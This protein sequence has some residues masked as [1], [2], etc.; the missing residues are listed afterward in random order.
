[1]AAED[2]IP[3]FYFDGDDGCDKCQDRTGHYKN[4]P[5]RPHDN[6]DCPIMVDFLE[7]EEEYRNKMQGEIDYEVAGEEVFDYFNDTDK[8]Q[9]IA[10]VVSVT[11]TGDISCDEEVEEVFDVSGNFEAEQTYS[12]Y[13]E[14]E[15]EPGDTLLVE[16]IGLYKNIPFGVEVWFVTDEVD[17]DGEKIEIFLHMAGDNIE[18]PAGLRLEVGVIGPPDVEP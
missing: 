10:D 9:F 14:H 2:M 6:C 13:F 16:A 18:V 17:K 5:D 8:K 1:M 3:F 15:L 4:Q 11:L 12:E 7:G